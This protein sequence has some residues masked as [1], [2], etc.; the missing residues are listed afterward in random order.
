M[1]KHKLLIPQETALVCSRIRKH[2]C[3]VSRTEEAIAHA[4]LTVSTSKHWYFRFLM[5]ITRFYNKL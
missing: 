2:Q 1:R 5:A 4:C 3:R